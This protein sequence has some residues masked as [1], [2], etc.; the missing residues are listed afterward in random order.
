MRRRLDASRCSFLRNLPLQWYGVGGSCGQLFGYS[1]SSAA[2]AVVNSLLIKTQPPCPFA[3][4]LTNIYLI[5]NFDF[6][7][8]SFSST[9][10]WSATTVW[11][12]LA[13]R[14][15]EHTSELQS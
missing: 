8:L 12:F 1:A 2:C 10:Y 7:P 6:N 11:S 13:E 4:S 15:E 14:S 5:S 3:F 9:R